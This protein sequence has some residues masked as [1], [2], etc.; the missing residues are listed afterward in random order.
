MMVPKGLAEFIAR[1][2]IIACVVVFPDSGEKL[3]FGDRSL[4]ESDYAVRTLFDDLSVEEISDHLRG[5]LLPR[6]VQQ[7]K[8][9]G[10]ICKPIENAIIGMY[11]HDE[12]DVVHRYH[13][14]KSLEA[15]IKA[16]W[17]GIPL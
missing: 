14:S 12:R 9:C 16:L 13:F 6:M 11:Y 8:V 17:T 5:Q 3:A 15:E 1:N 2:N 7:G 4:L 10:V